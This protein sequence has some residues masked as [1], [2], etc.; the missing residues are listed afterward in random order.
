MTVLGIFFFFS[1]VTSVS[2]FYFDR[3]GDSS[4]IIMVS[5]APHFVASNNDCSVRDYDMEKFQLSQ[6]LD[7]PWPVNVSLKL[8][9]FCFSNSAK[10][11]MLVRYDISSIWNV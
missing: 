5:G 1:I 8:L 6:L 9:F 7:F 10:T 3:L 4:D 11:L 2:V